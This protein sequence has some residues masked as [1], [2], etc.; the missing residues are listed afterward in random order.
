MCYANREGNTAYNTSLS[1]QQGVEKEN[2]QLMEITNIE[3]ELEYSEL[4]RDRT[5]TPLMP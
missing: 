3:Q 2:N 1:L 4:E 5:L